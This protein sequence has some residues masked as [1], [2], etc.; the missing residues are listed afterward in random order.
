MSVNK[1]SSLIIP[2]VIMLMLLGEVIRAYRPPI[3]GKK[4]RTCSLLITSPKPAT[5]TCMRILV[6]LI[7]GRPYD[8]AKQEWSVTQIWEHL[9][10]RSRNG[11][12]CY[13]CFKMSIK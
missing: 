11:S 7:E 4:R 13:G 8:S 10:S 6:P 12:L 5:C 3:F 1:Q 2:M 9:A